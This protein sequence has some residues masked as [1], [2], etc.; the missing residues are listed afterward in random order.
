[1]PS[2]FPTPM[3][4]HIH[5]EILLIFLRFQL[6]TQTIGVE[7]SMGKRSFLS[8]GTGDGLS[9]SQQEA[10]QALSSLMCMTQRFT[11]SCENASLLSQENSSRTLGAMPRK[12]VPVVLPKTQGLAF[13][14]TA[15]WQQDGC[16]RSHCV[17]SAVWSLARHSEQGRT[18]EPPHSIPSF[19]ASSPTCREI[20]IVS[21]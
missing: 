1:M 13:N 15:G 14:M 2:P 21:E 11:C 10:V 19:D 16:W 6:A 5:I 20:N 18:S 4:V 7:Q 12:H 8:P 9:S 3:Y 17:S